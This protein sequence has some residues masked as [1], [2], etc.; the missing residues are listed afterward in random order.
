MARCGGRGLRGSFDAGALDYFVP[1]RSCGEA[2]VS[3]AI[4]GVL[5][6]ARS[7]ALLLVPCRK[8]GFVDDAAGNGETTPSAL[9]DIE[10]VSCCS[11]CTRR[12]QLCSSSPPPAPLETILIFVGPENTTISRR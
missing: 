6:D 10:A 2:L 1:P 7:C 12:L 9:S 4:V 8:L 3:V 5:G 11:T